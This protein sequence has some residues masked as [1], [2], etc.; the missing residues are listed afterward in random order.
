MI[1]KTGSNAWLVSADLRCGICRI[2]LGKAGARMECASCS[3]YLCN[4]CD[5]KGLF[6]GY[7]SLGCIDAA[8]GEVLLQ[9]P[10]WVDYKARRYLAAAGAPKG[11]L[12]ADVWRM[13]VAP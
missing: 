4:L 13:K 7:Y 1:P 5:R 12:E 3:W 2:S 8:T 11:N 6:K 10:A 9:E